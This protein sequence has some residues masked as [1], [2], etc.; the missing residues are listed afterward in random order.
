MIR[1]PPY[2]IHTIEA[3]KLSKLLILTDQSRVNNG[4]EHDTYRVKIK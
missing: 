3:I 1:L 2:I 4:Y